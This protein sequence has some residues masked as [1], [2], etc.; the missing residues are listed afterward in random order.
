MLIGSLATGL[1][2]LAILGLIPIVD[3][4]VGLATAIFGMGSIVA[5]RIKL[6]AESR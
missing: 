1:A 3:F 4:L 6:R 2:I 5:S